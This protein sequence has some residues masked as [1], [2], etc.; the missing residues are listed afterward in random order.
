MGLLAWMKGQFIDIIEWMDDTNDTLVW[1]FPRHN[2][3]IKN[4]AQLIVR[5]GQ[6]AL[7]VLEGK[8]G[9]VYQ[10][11]MY[12]LTTQNMPVMSSL[13]GWKYGFESPFKCEV[14]FINTKQYIDM[15]WGTMSP[16]MLPDPQFEMVRV[17]AYGI[18]S[19]RVD[20]DRVQTFFK[21]LVGTDGLV[22]LD[23]ITGALKRELVSTFAQVVAQSKVP[24]L[25]LAQN[26]SVLEERCIQETT[27]S[28][29]NLG[30]I[31][32][33]F[34]IENITLPPEVQ[35]AMDQRASMRAVG[36]L[37]EF[38]QYQAAQ[39]VRDA[40]QQPGGM[41]GMGVGMGAGVGMGQI[42]AAA[43]TGSQNSSP[44]AP[45]TPASTIASRLKQLK[46]LH[47]QGLIDADAFAAKRDAILAEI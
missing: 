3:E 38:T 21:D 22:T 29:N 37:G 41:A 16:I 1:R 33:S 19:V 6:V 20:P 25:Q 45:S 42:L 32:N 26:F 39:A 7:F 14:Y 18:Y 12:T 11:G 2:R 47:E 10:P 40:A 43:M 4:G 8:M 36:D 46:D 23:E 30:L 24:A 9:D 35:Q 5:E 15:K 34:V 31:L 13:D 28:F 44:Q 17:R 27:P